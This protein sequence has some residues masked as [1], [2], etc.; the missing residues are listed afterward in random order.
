MGKQVERLEYKPYLL[1][2]DSSQ[3]TFLIFMDI[4]ANELKLTG[5]IIEVS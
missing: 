5:S 3:F 4:S 1:I 2:A